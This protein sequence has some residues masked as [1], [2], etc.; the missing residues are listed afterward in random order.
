MP[1]TVNVEIVNV[2]LPAKYKVVAFD[3]FDVLIRSCVAVKLEEKV[4][5]LE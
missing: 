1:L 5:P 4:T 2:E 3:K